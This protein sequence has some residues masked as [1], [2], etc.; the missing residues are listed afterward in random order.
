MFQNNKTPLEAFILRKMNKNKILNKIRDLKKG[1]RAN[2]GTKILLWTSILTLLN[3][4]SLNLK[5]VIL[6]TFNNSLKLKI[7]L[8]KFKNLFKFNKN[9]KLNLQLKLM[10]IIIMII[11][12]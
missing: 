7:T 10:K 11:I 9:K 1:S 8:C 2:L 4:N 3:S 12:F 6:L 5:K